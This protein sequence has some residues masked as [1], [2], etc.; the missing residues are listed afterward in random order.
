VGNNLELTK[1]QCFVGIEKSFENA[2]ALIKDAKLLLNKGSFGHSAALSML[3]I[4]ECGKAMFLVVVY[5]GQTD[6]DKELYDMIFKRH[7]PR[8]YLPLLELA[9]S[10]SFPKADVEY[11][12]TLAPTL[13][14]VKQRG[15]YVDFL[16]GKLVTPQDADLEKIANVNLKYAKRVLDGLLS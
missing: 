2:L 8:L 16:E 5:E 15:L 13:N 1:E 11:V 3:A 6:L 9:L 7:V 12:K 4:E 10:K 14:K